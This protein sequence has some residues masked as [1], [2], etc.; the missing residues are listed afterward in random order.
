M[1][2]LAALVGLAADVRRT[3]ERNPILL[4]LIGGTQTRRRQGRQ[5]THLFTMGRKKM[6]PAGG[7]EPTA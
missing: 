1:A 4:S 7:I 3:H 6:V 2:G 5:N